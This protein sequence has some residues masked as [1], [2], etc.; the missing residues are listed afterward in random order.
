MDVDADL[1]HSGLSPQKSA[2]ASCSPKTTRCW[3]TPC[4]RARTNSASWSI[5]VRDGLA[6][7]RDL[8]AHPYT[9]AVL[10]L[11]LPSKDGTKVLAALRRARF[12]RG[13]PWR[14][15]PHGLALKV[16]ASKALG[17]LA[18]S[19]KAPLAA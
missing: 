15:R 19:L 6:A 4:R 3:A 5:G 1:G 14:R 13:S 11:G 18:V 8:R 9:A 12:G 7:E 16:D 17:G 2:C 10:D